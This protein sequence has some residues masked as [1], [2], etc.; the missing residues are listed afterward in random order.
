[1]MMFC[2]H[3]F[4][5]LILVLFVYLQSRLLFLKLSCLLSFWVLWLH[6]FI[7]MKRWAKIMM[8]GLICI[9][10]WKVRDKDKSKE[11]DM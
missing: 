10:D 1:M 4:S 2:V 8:M 5:P 7:I 11:G 9:F 6:I 3:L